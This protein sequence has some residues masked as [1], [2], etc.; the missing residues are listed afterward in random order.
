MIR[1]QFGINLIS[2][3]IGDIEIIKKRKSEEEERRKDNEKI[4]ERNGENH[5]W[6]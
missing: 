5:E 3:L 4:K 2:F 6:K 1:C